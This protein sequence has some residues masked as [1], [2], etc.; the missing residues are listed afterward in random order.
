DDVRVVLLLLLE[1][2]F[3]ERGIFGGGE[4]DRIVVPPVEDD[5]AALALGER[6]RLAARR[7]DEPELHLRLLLLLVASSPPSPATGLRRLVLGLLRQR[8]VAEKGDVL[9][10]G[11]PAWMRAII[12]GARED[13]L[14][15]L[16]E[17]GAHEI[18][19]ALPLGLVRGGL[20]PHDPAAVGRDLEVGRRLALDDVVGRPRFLVV[21]R[22]R[23]ASGESE[24]EGDQTLQ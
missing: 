15:L 2:R 1:G 7:V 17:A 24:R 10:V 20:D 3:V 21:L 19:D 9:A 16:G 8:A 22:G 5:E 23:G 11:R 12:L 4:E 13:G 14:A 6:P 18:G